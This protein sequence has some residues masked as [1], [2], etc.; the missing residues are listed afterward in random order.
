MHSDDLVECLVKLA[1]NNSTNFATYNI[2]SDNIIDIHQIEKVTYV[3]MKNGI[4]KENFIKFCEK[5]DLN[6]EYYFEN[7]QNVFI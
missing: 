4:L 2:G 7:Y 3:K 1:F 6:H 5:H